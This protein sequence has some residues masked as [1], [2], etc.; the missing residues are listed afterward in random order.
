MLEVLLFILGVVLGGFI[1]LNVKGRSIKEENELL[2]D[3]SVEKEL[4]L[5]EDLDE[6]R[7]TIK[8]I[9]DRLSKGNK[10]PAATEAFQLAEDYLNATG[11][12]LL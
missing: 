7:D 6:A 3:A 12:Q 9:R 4:M 5:Q 1:F 8:R 2:L 11:R 10:I